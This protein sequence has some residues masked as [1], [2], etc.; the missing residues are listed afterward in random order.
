[1]LSNIHKEENKKWIHISREIVSFNSEGIAKN[2]YKEMLGNPR[3]SNFLNHDEVKKRLTYS[4][5]AWIDSSFEFLPDKKGI[6]NY[7]N[8]Q[9]KIG[10]V[11]AKIGLPISLVNYGMY[12]IKRDIMSLII[13]SDLN[14]QDL[15]AT[16]MLI[17]Q[18]LECAL[19]IINES[20][21]HDLVINEKDS[22]AF[23]LQFSASNLA[24]DCERLRTSLSDWMR[25]L[26]L[27]T[28]SS[29]AIDPAKFPTIR[30]SSFGLWM[31]HKAKLFI[32]GRVEYSTLIKL[33]D[34][35]DEW[36]HKLIQSQQNESETQNCLEKLNNLVSKANWI[37][38]EIAKDIISQ[39]NGKDT[40]TKLFNRRYLDMV[41]R[42]E[43]MVS[44]TTGMVYGLIMIDIDH[45]KKINDTYGHD[46][47]DRILEQIAEILISQIRAGDF[48]FRLGGEE[49]LVIIS[50]IKQYIVNNVA[51]KIRSVVENTPCILM[52][53]KAI[54]VT[55]SIGTALHDGHPDFSRTMKKADDALYEAK[56]NGRNQVVCAKEI[57]TYADLMVNSN[58]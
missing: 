12:L 34:D 2:F 10:H 56:N 14:K 47:G 21:E 30:Q 17:S 39:D 53:K 58:P 23:K 38:S 49:F 16:M 24:L 40:L 32:S 41:L 25:D 36:M 11:H 55:I 6:K 29:E 26:L 37:L 33:L 35:M 4:M 9:L 22:H 54:N 20:Y 19:Q 28:R 42:H 15:G 48:V 3:A 18:I 44:M 43:T 7:I 46:N 57:L 31:S 1:M 52:D 8:S 50:D 45:F 13:A 27:T 51:E 5:K